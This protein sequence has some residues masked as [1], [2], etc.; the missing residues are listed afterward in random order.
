MNI[1]L[2]LEKILPNNRVKTRYLE[3]VSFASDAGFYHLVPKAVVRPINEEEIIDLFKFSQKHAIPLVFRAGGTS[4]SG[5]S[6]TDGILVDLS[7]SWNKINVE[8]N[9]NTVRLQP[10]ITGAMVNAYL[11]KFSR[12]IGPDPASISAAMVGGIVS[13]NSSG[14]CC[15]VKL[16]SYHTVNYLRFILPNGNT[17]STEIKED[18]TR[19]E[20]IEYKLFTNL[21]NLRAKILT[22]PE[23]HDKIRKKY[24]TKNTV[25]YSLNAF[26]DFKHPLDI[27]AHLL[28]GAE[29]TLA[30]I[31]EV[32]L[33]TVPDY[34]HKST[35]LLYFSTISD[36]CNAIVPLNNSGALMVELMD[37]ASLR[38]V[39]NMESI[40]DF[41][42]T[43]PE[44]AAAL[45]IEYQ[46]NNIEELHKKVEFFLK[47]SSSL[48]LLK[49][50][51]F[52]SVPSE[53]AF[54]W[55]V[56]KGL[57]PAVGAIRA[58]GT[59]VILE[60]VAF[61]VEKMSNA[62]VDLQQ[63]FIKH[64]Y[65]NAIIFGHAKDGNIHFVVTQ[66]FNSEKEIKRYDLFIK[67][68]VKLVIE[69]YDGTLKAEHGTGRN[70]A[71]FVETEWGGLGYEIMKILKQS[72][73]PYLLLNPGVII[74]DD[75]NT[76]I[77]NLKE[78]P[79]VESEVDTCIECGYCEH[80]CPSKNLTTTPRRRIV[81]RRALKK[82]KN[83]GDKENYKLLKKQYKYDGLD[84]CAVDGLCATA[85]PVDINTGDLVK[86]LRRE[87]HSSISN[88]VALIVAK[89][90]NIVQ[91]VI[92][93]GIKS[94]M[95]INNVFGK[96]SMNKLTTQIRK[97]IP[98]TPLWTSQMISPPKLLVLKSNTLKNKNESK[99]IYFPSCISRLLGT[100][101]E[102]EKNIMETFIS[103]C[104]K[105]GIS[106]SVLKNA[107]NSCC[108]Q[109]F[110][111]KGHQ[112]AYNYTANIIVE[113]L[114]NATQSGII[115]VVIDVSSC[116]YSLKQL[117]SVLNIVNKEKYQKLKIYDAVEFLH[118]MVLPQIQIK[119]RKNNIIL[120]SVCA[121]EKMK[122][123]DKFL[124]IAKHFAKDVI[125]PKTNGC[126]GMAGDRGFLFPELTKSAI[127]T[128]KQE[129]QNVSCDG[130]YASTKT[131]EM[132][133]SEAINKNY[134]SILYLADE[135]I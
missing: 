74:N 30:F 57:F 43:L 11:K 64:N 112:D 37:R 131:C 26:I 84:T 90:F 98:N 115:P 89:N 134:E 36:A 125:L 100:Y 108:G 10:G 99:I 119:Q 21:S 69:K 81:V 32:V 77:K 113:K 54:L 33:K 31:S 47:S 114:W 121:L 9:G 70:M 20:E 4:L 65:N 19:F 91:W 83:E 16:N 71:P 28:I 44:F 7:S 110:S 49:T 111:S 45:L 86:R 127:N 68:V 76:H 123:E 23:L 60:D 3:L 46:E 135:C 5:Q 27:L 66:S 8:E 25:G 117:S 22:N 41:V 116:A 96:K 124:K 105:S 95:A 72:I 128:E 35:A 109:I 80:K 132:A 13:N 82:L 75:K 88:S 59:T 94:G 1:K 63:L 85:C 120:H 97:V 18:Y 56:R 6:I 101:E 55:K 50:I 48:N 58:S 73:D 104:E 122:I 102:K 92:R 129:V 67:D 38:A 51:E 2:E 34:S 52:T 87:N 61:P 29:G 62:I 107:N 15:G 12:K 103:V 17:Y 126:C 78:L 14:M 93:T 42:K 40:P 118:N 39:E 53:M 130:Y 106:L 79:T 24:L 133:L